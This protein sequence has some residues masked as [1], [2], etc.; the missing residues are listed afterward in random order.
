MDRK[1]ALSYISSQFGLSGEKA[2]KI[3]KITE[4]S[5]NR[6]LDKSK[7]AV[8]KGDN[9]TLASCMHTLKSNFANL[10]LMELSEKAKDLEVKIKQGEHENIEDKFQEIL[11]LWSDYSSP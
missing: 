2:L 5:I 9:E 1:S 10:G 11:S 7:E 3:V 6:L 4:T 8:L